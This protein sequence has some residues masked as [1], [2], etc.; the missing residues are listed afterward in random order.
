MIQD[1]NPH[2]LKNGYK[3]I[4]AEKSDICLTY[5]NGRI[6]LKCVENRICFPAFEDVGVDVFRGIY[7]FSMDNKNIFLCIDD[8]P[9]IGDYKYVSMSFLRG[10]VPKETAY[11]G[12][13][14][15]HLY[16]WYK[17]NVFCGRC[18]KLL[19]HDNKERMLC[20]SYCGNTVFP[21]ICPAVIVCVRNKD[22]ILITKYAGREY[23]KYALIAGFN[24]IGE[25][26][27]ETVSREVMEEVGIKVKNIEY[28]K[29]QPWGFTGGLLMGFFCDVDGDSTVTIDRK[30]LSFGEWADIE[31][32]RDMDDGVSLTCEMMRIAYERFVSDNSDKFVS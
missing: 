9:E 22:K 8:I 26:I 6:L 11:A 24:E 13:V 29:S 27:E 30:E 18:G 4:G 21:K 2:K 25:T 32:V 23:K 7:A 5:K 1:I 10:A 19:V 28:Y 20:C 12:V 16:M 15:Y 17:D 31:K 14:G 3:N